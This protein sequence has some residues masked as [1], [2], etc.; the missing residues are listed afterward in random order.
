MEKLYEI[1][2]YNYVIKLDIYNIMFF[3]KARNRTDKR[4]KT[5]IQKAFNWRLETIQSDL[6]SV[7]SLDW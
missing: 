2:E 6:F 5:W 7:L 4:E 1:M 3:N